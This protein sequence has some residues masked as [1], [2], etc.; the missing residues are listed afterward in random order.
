MTDVHRESE[1]ESESL[2]R[3][4]YD[5]VAEEYTEMARPD[6]PGKPLER[7]LL[8]AFAE[9]VR[10]QGEVADL[11]C[12][13]GLVTGYLSG[14]GLPM[15]GL[16]LSESM[17]TVARRENPGLR[18]ERGS[19]LSTGMADGSLAGIV[20]YYSSI[21]TPMDRLP[22]LFGEFRRILRPGGHLFLAFQVGDRHRTLDR[23]FGHPVTLDFRRRRPERMA[24][25][26]EE[27]GFVGCSRTVRE[28]APDSDETTPHAFLTARRV[29]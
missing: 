19:M 9:L 3:V 14:L 17:L 22:A 2:T 24:A 25:L 26:L 5:A 20:S 12:G 18:F 21:H 28:A 6:L 4:F 15:R 29:P 8:G 10:G 7:A 11:G 16:D 1:A 13:P 23:P 27:A